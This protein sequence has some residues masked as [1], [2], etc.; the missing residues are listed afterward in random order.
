M[1]QNSIR[2]AVTGGIG[3]G[4]SSVCNIIKERGF[5]VFSCD[6]IY[7]ELLEVGNVTSEIAGEFGKGILTDGKVDKKKLS[8]C[9]FNDAA[10]LEKLNEITHKA[11]FD[12]IFSRAEKS[13]GI[14]FVEVPLL[15]EG[16]Y[17]SL[18]DGVIVVLRKVEDRISSVV[19]RDGLSQADVE[20]R[21]KKQ[22]NYD[23]CDF[24]KYYV[25]HNDGNFNDLERITDDIMLKI[26]NDFRS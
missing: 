22:H 4:K 15:F 25:I 17:Q 20:K 12:E 10:K 7:S 5:T 21:I 23:N 19:L 18:F 13:D 14:V 6:E 3:S 8:E 26:A 2:I 24:A 11:I 1:K 9:V 16:N